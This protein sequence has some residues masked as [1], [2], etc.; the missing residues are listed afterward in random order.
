MDCYYT[1]FNKSFTNDANKVFFGPFTDVIL[2]LCDPTDYTKTCVKLASQSKDERI[3]RISFSDQIHV[4]HETKVDKT[5]AYKDA[6]ALANTNKDNMDAVLWALEGRSNIQKQALSNV[7]EQ[8]N[9]RSQ[10]IPRCFVDTATLIGESLRAVQSL[11]F[12][13]IHTI[14][15]HCEVDMILIKHAYKETFNVPLDKDISEK[16]CGSFQDILLLLCGEGK[17]LK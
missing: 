5:L 11:Y 10:S 7:Y 6:R 3:Q 14:V 1:E 9:I 17:Q 2:M 8:L 12:L 4:D 15:S 16:T 13:L